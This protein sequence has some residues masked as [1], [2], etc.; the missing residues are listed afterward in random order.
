MANQEILGFKIEHALTVLRKELLK[1]WREELRRLPVEE[2]GARKAETA[3]VRRLRKPF[4]EPK[5]CSEINLV[6]LTHVG[7]HSGGTEAYRCARTPCRELGLCRALYEITQY[8]LEPTTNPTVFKLRDHAVEL[9]TLL[10]RASK[11]VIEMAE[12]AQRD[13]RLI[14]VE[15]DGVSAM[16]ALAESR[17]RRK[18]TRVIPTRI[19][20]LFAALADVAGPYPGGLNELI[21]SPQHRVMS[22]AQ[23]LLG[24]VYKYLA[25]SGYELEQI[26]RLNLTEEAGTIKQRA[27]RIRT[28][29]SPAEGKE[30]IVWPL[31]EALSLPP[32][33]GIEPAQDQ[34]VS[35]AEQSSAS[36]HDVPKRTT[37]A[38]QKAAVER[39]K[40]AS[41]TGRRKRS[42]AAKSQPK[43]AAPTRSRI[44]VDTKRGRAAKKPEE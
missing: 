4:S 12:V 29:L 38:G 14:P 6:A 31:P 35:S 25:Q 15:K 37:G 30:P 41:A 8:Q 42:K 5:A 2:R 36:S 20:A 43:R 39:S 22:S 3:G 28:K 34:D 24:A 9:Q 40:K 27:K 26:A 7:R 10:R 23:Y 33:R 19:D 44:A 21:E 16:Y 32:Q 13:P 17:E 11:H 1:V 18:L